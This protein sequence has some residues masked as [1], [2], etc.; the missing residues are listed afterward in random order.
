MGKA[1][2]K[3][4]C[5]MAIATKP[6]SIHSKTMLQSQSSMEIQYALAEQPEIIN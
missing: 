1:A 4:S 2:K 3:Q 5:A 6:P